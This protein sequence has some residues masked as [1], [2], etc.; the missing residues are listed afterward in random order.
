[1]ASILNVDKIRATGSTTDGLT[2]DS[3]GRVFTPA[4][5][6]FRAGSNGTQN[7]LTGIIIY[8]QVDQTT[9]GQYNTGMYDITTGKATIPIAGLYFYT[10][11][12]YPQDQAGCDAALKLQIGGTGTA[13][14]I[15]AHYEQGSQNGYPTMRLTGALKLAASDVLY[16]NINSG[17]GHLNGNKSHFDMYLIG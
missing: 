10:A 9:K 2:V 11:Q 15:D 17:T 1:M 3:S 8:N 7:N 12:L 13:H 6:G 4:R 14:D 16:V 5:P